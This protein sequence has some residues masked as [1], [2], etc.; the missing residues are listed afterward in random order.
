MEKMPHDRN[1]K[2][3]EV[4]DIVMGRGYNIKHDIIGPALSVT[5]AESCNLTVGIVRAFKLAGY[6]GADL[7]SG[8]LFVTNFGKL[9]SCYILIPDI[10]Y[11]A[12]RDFEI[13]QK[14][15]GTLPKE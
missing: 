11:G 10:E 14:A 4:G 1:G 8:K 6:P 9:E 3:V 5:A 2:L 7:T 15:D 12:T 13:V